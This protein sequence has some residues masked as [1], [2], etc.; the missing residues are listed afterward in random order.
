MM[1][2]IIYRFLIVLA[3]VL[4]STLSLVAQGKVKGVVVDQ[5]DDPIVGALIFV[6]DF[7]ENNTTTNTEGEFEMSVGRKNVLLEVNYLGFDPVVTTAVFGSNMKIIMKEKINELDEVV[8]LGYGTVRKTDLTGAVSAVSL[9]TKAEDTPI[10]SVDQ[11]LQGR[12]AGVNISA[13][14]GAPGDGMS[15]QIRGVSTLSGNTAPL[16]VIDGFPIEAST[17]T[18]AGSTQE[19][20]QQPS[21]NP[22]ASIN[23]N[24]I[25][26]IQ[27]LKDASATAIYGS[28]ATNGVI[29]VTTKQG[30]ESQV[31]VDFNVR[32]DISYIPNPYNMLNGYEY[33]LFKNEIDRT[34]KGYDMHGNVNPTTTIPRYTDYQMDKYKIYHTDWQKLMYDTA[35]SQD[36]QLSVNGGTKAIQ[37]NITGGYTNQEGVILNTGL[38]RYSFRTNFKM[39]LTKG[40]TL[41]TNLNYSQVEQ[42]QTSHSQATTTNQMIYRVLTT[43]PIQLPGDVIYDDVDLDY[44]AVDNPYVMATENKDLLKQQFYVINAALNYEFGNGFSIKGA[45]NVNLVNGSRY[46]YFPIGTNTG[47][48]T[49][50]SAF[51]GENKRQNIVL[52]TTVNYNRTLHDIHRINAV[53][54][55][56]FEERKAEALSIH[57]GDF[58][59]NDLQYYSIG[60]ASNTS[61]KGSNFTQTKLSSFLGRMNY[62]LWDRYVFT[63][64]GRYD[65][66]SVLA[67]GNQ[68]K[69]FPSFAVA[70][71]LNQEQF[72]KN[73][74]IMS[75][76]KLRLSYGVTGNQNINF[77]APYAIM[78]HRRAI[79]DDQAAHGLVNGKLPNA[80]LGWEST[81]S[82]NVGLDLNFFKDRVRMTFDAYQRETKDMLINFGLPPSSGY[83][84]IPFNMGQIT[85]KGL[86]LEVATDILRENVKWSVGGNIYLNRNNVDDLGGNELLG[87]KY[88][89]GGGLFDQ[90]IHITK[91]GHK[92]G[93]FYGYVVD[94]IYQNYDEAKNAPIDNPR[95][96]PGSIRYLDISG[97]DGLPDG[98]I[99]SDDM[100]IIGSPEP[101]FNYGLN[102]DVSWKGF[103]ISLIFTGQ[104]GG[105][106][107]NM[108]R[109]V[110]NSYAD[111]NH[112]ITR[113][114]WEGRWQGEGT[115]NFY[116]A[117][118]GSK[119]N[120]YFNKRFSSNMLEDATY[121]RLKTLTLAYQFKLPKVNAIRSIRVFCTAS[122]LMTLTKYTGYDPE[123]S[124]TPG[125]L[126]PN[127]DYAAYPTPRTFSL[128]VK[129]GF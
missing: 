108:N 14:S 4:F 32:T 86:E 66:S 44:V 52:E 80:D 9:G 107:A 36:Y 35:I 120:S 102:T 13:N 118:D 98:E 20:Y 77:A 124:I 1:K 46:V 97:P 27:V 74:K 57:V 123:V 129:L 12:I 72:M 11:F 76:A 3:G 117:V 56:T 23:P 68:W 31:R 122:N 39:Q 110:V 61:N 109:Y 7:K 62:S 104:Y 89:A 41:Q 100:T 126:S 33:A 121:F 6:R 106:I 128:G 91:A 96:T 111:S 105:K 15:V 94:G 73:I 55:Y 103:S 78:N 8:I 37:Y 82:Y 50:G 116:P 79:I 18:I 5:N 69:F 2:K 16:Y 22:L 48:Q 29:I 127:V 112:N 19:L 83:G 64:T 30:K 88:L 47:N 70:W 65:G 10:T 21:M 63:A 92:I 58:A 71:R 125:A 17:A 42:K 49:N 51:R 24:D 119:K 113:E 67:T 95:A 34:D 28:R 75:N 45:G 43:S 115:S 38:E 26:S 59:G 84:A 53:A 93:S 90:S 60:D 99:T 25:E 85:N 101:L 40:L 87:A 81:T 114:A 54:G